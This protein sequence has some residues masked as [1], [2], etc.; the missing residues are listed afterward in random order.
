MH[1]NILEIVR[2][3]KVK[4]FTVSITTNGY[5]LNEALVSKL[6]PFVDW[7]GISVDS[8][9]EETEKILGRG[10]EHHVAK[11]A[12][13]CKLIH[14]YGIRLKI[15]TLV[16]KLNCQEDMK[17]FIIGIDPERWKKFS[18]SSYKRTK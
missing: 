3:S 16:T 15:N 11:S 13:V 6:S 10:H 7:I 2:M 14:K 12:E 9:N 8:E 4:G 5:F 17:N 1:P 18:V